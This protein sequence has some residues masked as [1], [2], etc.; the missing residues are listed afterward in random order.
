MGANKNGQYVYSWFAPENIDSFDADISPLLH[1]LWRNDYL[2][3]TDYL[4]TVQ[5]GT[6]T[7]HSV[8]NVTFSARNFSMSVEPGKPKETPT[9]PDEP[10]ESKPSIGTLGASHNLISGVMPLILG[11]F[12][13]L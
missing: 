2:D 3:D 12:L 4:G 9:T 7:F 6:E 5:F 8:S 1:Y 10:S 13:F 11:A